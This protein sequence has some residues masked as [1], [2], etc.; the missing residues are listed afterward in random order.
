M[1]ERACEMVRASLPHPLSPSVSLPPSFLNTTAWTKKRDDRA[2]TTTAPVYLSTPS[3]EELQKVNNNCT[4][5]IAVFSEAETCFYDVK[6][7][8]RCMV[9]HEPG[10]NCVVQLN[11]GLGCREWGGR[12]G[13]GGSV[14]EGAVGLG[15]GWGGGVEGGGSVL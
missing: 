15:G 11:A 5:V 4:P 14:G 10:S 6:E 9:S 12:E 1:R 3:K 13:V 8:I 7:W 2:I